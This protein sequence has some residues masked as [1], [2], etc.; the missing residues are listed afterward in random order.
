M[1]E[2]SAAPT[3]G[4]RLLAGVV[5]AL[6]AAQLVW[7]AATAFDPRL[8]GHAPG[9]ASH[10]AA[11]GS[12]WAMLVTLLLGAAAFSLTLFSGG[13][14]RVGTR[15]PLLV[16]A[17]SAV[18]AAPVAFFGYLPC[19]GDGPVVWDAFNS[20]LSLFFGSFDKP[21]GPGEACGYPTPVGMHIARGLALLATASG[22]TTVLLSLS[23]SQLDRLAARRARV[24]TVLT[25]TDERSWELIDRVAVRR[26]P[27]HRTAL[28]AAELDPSATE[29]ARAAGL[30]V[31]RVDADDPLGLRRGLRLERIDKIYLL[32]AD[33]G[34]N[35]SRVEQIQR[36][37]ARGTRPPASG[38]LIV[39]ARIDDPWHADEWRKRLVGDPR[40]AA[41]AVG[42]YEATSA[43]LIAR[44][45]ISTTVENRSDAPPALDRLLMVGGGALTLALCTELSQLGREL[46]FLGDEASLPA[47]T[48][49]AGNA[50]ELVDDHRV[51]Q[52][53][54]AFDPLGVTAVDDEPRLAAVLE[55]LG[56]GTGCAVVIT[57][58][59]T[60]L[61]TQ[62]GIRL[63]ALPVFE[64]GDVAATAQTPTVGSL[65]TFGLSLATPQADA[66]ER[67]ARLIHE[68]YRRRHPGAARAVPWEE[69]PEFYRQSNRRQLGV[70]RRELA[71]LGRTW[72]PSSAEPDQGAALNADPLR[73]IQDG[74]TVFDLSPAELTQL[75]R[76]EHESWMA[77]YR[78][79]GW[80]HAPIRDDA[81]QRHPDLLEWDELPQE[82]REVAMAGVVDTLFQLRALGHRAV[83]PATEPPAWR[84]YRRFGVVWATRLTE[85]HPWQTATG[86][87]LVGQPGDW[88]VT[89]AADS[90]RTVT[91]ASFR[92][93]H[94]Q[95]DAERWQRSAEVDARPVRP[96]ERI[97]TQEGPTVAGPDGWVVRDDSGNHWIVPEAKF[98]D[99]Y[100]LVE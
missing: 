8:L 47:I 26:S 49:L 51:L 5:L 45:P 1:A 56:D 97:D 22:A 78:N 34:W 65:V 9:W 80:S 39:V 68:R 81:R 82:R 57:T 61:G 52:R 64:A 46:Q 21:F 12:I 63:P 66:W 18:S 95:L 38:P 32:A 69:L 58:P 27:G 43:A 44:L 94:L 72:R 85:P 7:L 93:T 55:W 90:V 20:T 17:W 60:R 100:R 71:A 25:G 4:P 40:I 2:D 59:G 41:D 92:A 70:V 50:G 79:A 16:S 53:R 84:R 36:L 33:D 37:L 91:D 73:P 86:E 30:L 99:G 83:R 15:T 67:A 87:T 54:F 76:A 3:L 74:L 19:P 13:D 88:L 48:V 24:L 29:R 28:L 75:A 96:G 10:L 62:L 6:Y 35:R 77:H 14:R 23:R 98:R 11:P 89:D 42:L 31:V